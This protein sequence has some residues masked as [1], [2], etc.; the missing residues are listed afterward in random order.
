M[1]TRKS[2]DRVAILA[3]EQ[4]TMMKIRVTVEDLETGE[5]ESREI[6]NDYI[7]VTAGECYVSSTQSWKNGTH[8]LIIKG[9]NKALE[10]SHDETNPP[11]R[12][13]RAI[14]HVIR[15]QPQRCR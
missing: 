4:E 2:F 14:N 3:K 13:G 7:I 12:R 11:H 6:M 5:T 15:A 1:D 9:R 10:G 8:Q